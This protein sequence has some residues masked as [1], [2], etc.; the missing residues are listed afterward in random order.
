M[1]EKQYL[2]VEDV[3]RRFGVTAS[4]IYRLAQRGKLPGFKIGGQWRFSEPL[5]ESWV[6]D[7]VTVERLR[8]EEV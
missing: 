1:R 5:L 6:L 8:S 4:T 3:A 2:S 7:Q